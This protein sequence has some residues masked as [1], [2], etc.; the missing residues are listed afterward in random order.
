MSE[1]WLLSS[2]TRV[3]FIIV[4]EAVVAVGVDERAVVGVEGFGGEGEPPLLTDVRRLDD[5]GA[6]VPVL[7]DLGAREALVGVIDEVKRHRARGREIADA[8]S[9]RALG[10]LDRADRLR[11]QEVKVRVALP[12][13][14]ADRVD[15]RAADEET[16]VESRDLDIEAAHEELIRLAAARVLD[17]EEAGDGLDDLLGPVAWPKR[18]LVLRRHRAQTA[19]ASIHRRAAERLGDDQRRLVRPD[20]TGD[21][22]GR[23]TQATATAEELAT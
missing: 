8:N 20:R 3:T 14:V 10:R 21:A 5:H 2:R 9:V 13:R 4:L 1:A 16:R 23:E 22:G 11:D 19:T 17:G 6:E 18:E 15:R 12:V 7:A